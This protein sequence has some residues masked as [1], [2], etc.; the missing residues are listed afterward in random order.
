MPRLPISYQNTVIYKLVCNDLNVP[1]TYVGHTTDFTKKKYA[2]KYSCNN[3][4]DK[5]YNFKVY[6][7]IRE[8]G[9]WVNW[10]ML[11]V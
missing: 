7:T 3:V 11:M 8:N 4:K 2:H 6:Q 1:Y 10:T 9:G 5:S